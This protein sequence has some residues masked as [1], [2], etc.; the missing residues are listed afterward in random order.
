MTRGPYRFY[1]P[2]P[3]ELGQSLLLPDHV[4]HQIGRVLRLHPGD[5]IVLFDG[6][7][8]DFIA[9]IVVLRPRE[10]WVQIQVV[11]P[12]RPIPPP[13]LT[14][15]QSLLRHDHF[16]L[17]IQKATELGV[18]RIIPLRARHSVVQLAEDAL[19]QRLHRWQKIVT[20]ASEQCGRGVLPV[21]EQPCTVDQAVEVLQG[22]QL[23]VFSETAPA[24]QILR[25]PLPPDK[26]V[27]LAIGPEGG[28]HRAELA[29]FAQA[30]ATFYSLG[31]L[32]L[33]AETAALAAIVRVQTL[34]T[35]MEALPSPRPELGVPPACGDD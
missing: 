15:F 33:R 25:V 6:S 18:R 16:D 26:P 2:G 13:P 31:P 7:E 22:E 3:L 5:H 35:L 17:V 34:A 30:N 21:I 4:A 14:L 19:Q 11:Q 12:S 8:S 32:I 23:F 27:A 9:E 28:W 29:R 20:E 1:V 10:T 24:H